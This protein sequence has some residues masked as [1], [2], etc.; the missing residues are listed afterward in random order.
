MEVLSER[1][2][3]GWLTRGPWDNLLWF[4]RLQDSL[5]ALGRVR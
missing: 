2:D 5:V 1:D 4:G 3:L